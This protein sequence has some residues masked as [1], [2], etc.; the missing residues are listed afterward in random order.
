MSTAYQI[1]VCGS[2]V[3]DP[4][5]TLEP[6]ASPTGPAVPERELS[7]L[8]ARGQA[9]LCG[10]FQAQFPG[11]AL[12]IE[13]NPRSESRPATVGRARRRLA[14]PV[15]PPQSLIPF[16]FIN[17][18]GSPA[19]FFNLKARAQFGKTGV[20]FTDYFQAMRQRPDRALISL[21][22]ILP[23]KTGGVINHEIHEIHETKALKP[24]GKLE[25]L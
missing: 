4:L 7:Q 2:I 15:P 20:K 22:W 11:D 8:A 17:P 25:V 1:V 18:A 6:V 9:S 10:V 19:G 3:P 14:A 5:Q 13:D 23:K 24:E 21:E 16:S 12:R